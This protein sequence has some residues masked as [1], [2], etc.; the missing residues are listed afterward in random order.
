MVFNIE[1]FRTCT[2]LAQLKFLTDLSTKLLKEE[3]SQKLIQDLE[4]VRATLTDPGS[5]ILHLSTSVSQLVTKFK[6]PA[7]YLSQVI[8]ENSIPNQNRSVL[9]S[10][11]TFQFKHTYVLVSN[12]SMIFNEV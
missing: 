12:A 9:F 2:V 7:S 1:N 4:L 10:I 3:E 11:G 5:M 8:P 6:Q